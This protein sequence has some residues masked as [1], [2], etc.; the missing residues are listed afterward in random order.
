MNK[1]SEKKKQ[2]KRKEDEKSRSQTVAMLKGMAVAY[3]ITCI[4]FIAYGLLLTYTGVSEERIPM[5]ALICTAV[6]AA[7]AGFDWAKCA[8]SRGILWGIFAGLVY[9]VIL[10]LLHGAAGNGFGFQMAKLTMLLVAIAGGGIGG[11]LGINLK[12]S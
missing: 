2:T 4:V 10:F 1:K 8:N 6:S 12:K 7:V 11:I 5:V 9:G 3:A